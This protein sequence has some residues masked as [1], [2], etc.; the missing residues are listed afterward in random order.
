M[1]TADTCTALSPSLMWLSAF[2]TP[3]YVNPLGAILLFLIWWKT[4]SALRGFFDSAKQLC[5]DEVIDGE[6]ER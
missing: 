5:S 3:M 6:E 2:N 4:V 1:K